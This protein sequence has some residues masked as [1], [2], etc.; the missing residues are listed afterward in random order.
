MPDKIASY[1]ELQQALGQNGGNAYVMIS[2]S[3]FDVEGKGQKLVGIGLAEDK[4]PRIIVDILSLKTEDDILNA[5][6]YAYTEG[7][8][9][10]VTAS[11]RVEEQYSY[12]KSISLPRMG[13][14]NEQA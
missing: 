7:I 3:T 14:S 10:A 6:H 8:F 1:T 13:V 9:T 2:T 5:L 4:R 12:G 11:R